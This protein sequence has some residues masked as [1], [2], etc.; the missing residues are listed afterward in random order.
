MIFAVWMWRP[1]KSEVARWE[2]NGYCQ[3]NNGE[4]QQSQGS[5]LHVWITANPGDK[6]SSGD[7]TKADRIFSLYL[8]VDAVATSYTKAAEASKA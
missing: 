2:R 7:E 1:V 8:V 5:E 3:A 6:L 4:D